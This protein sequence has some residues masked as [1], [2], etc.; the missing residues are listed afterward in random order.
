MIREEE[1]PEAERLLTKRGCVRSGS[2]AVENG[3]MKEL[4]GVYSRSH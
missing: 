4:A 1:F 2:V 3:D